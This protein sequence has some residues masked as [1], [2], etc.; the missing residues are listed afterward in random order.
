[1]TVKDISD[2]YLK[3]RKVD[4]TIPD[5]VLDFMKDAAIEKINNHCAH[6]W[7]AYKGALVCTKCSKYK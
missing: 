2:A 1:M 6:N 4:N 7:V 5:E 3:I